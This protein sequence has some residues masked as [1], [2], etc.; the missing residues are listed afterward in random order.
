MSYA[1]QRSDDVDLRTRLRE[2][3][4]E[5]HRFGYQR[6]GI[7]LAREGLVMNHKKLLRLYR[8]EGLPRQATSRAQACTG[9]ASA[10]GAA[11]RTEPA[12]EPRPRQRHADRRTRIPILEVVDDFRREKVGLVV[13]TS[14]SALRP[15]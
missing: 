12:A 14:L 2:I 5:C 13:D 6:L 10:D 1:H 4:S 7:M 3:A 8:E 15:R 11:A 9:N